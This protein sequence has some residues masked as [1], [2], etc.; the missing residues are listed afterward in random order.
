VIATNRAIDKI[1]IIKKL[2]LTKNNIISTVVILAIT[3]RLY[4]K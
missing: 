4:K 3:N 1:K 2:L